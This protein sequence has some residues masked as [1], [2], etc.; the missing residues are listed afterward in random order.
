MSN[1]KVLKKFRRKLFWLGFLKI[2]MLRYARPQLIELNEQKA[3][4][5]IKLNRRTK[6]HLN[7][8][9]MG[10]LCIG[11][12]ITPGILSFYHESL[13]KGKMTFIFKSMKVEFLRRAE[14]DV[15]FECAEGDKLK[16]QIEQAGSSGERVNQLVEIKAFDESNDQI[17][18]FDMEVSVR[19]KP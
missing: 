7:S 13:Y 6:N 15:R 18:R 4:I 1:Q 12:D 9:Y 14:S 5:K 19:V 11:A 2:K 10:A 3:I 8:M 17:A 16:A